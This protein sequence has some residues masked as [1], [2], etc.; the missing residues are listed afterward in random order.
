MNFRQP[1][2]YDHYMHDV[3]KQ[4]YLCVETLKN[5]LAGCMVETVVHY[6]FSSTISKLTNIF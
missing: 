2:V 5:R 6:E 4:T 1:N 3:P